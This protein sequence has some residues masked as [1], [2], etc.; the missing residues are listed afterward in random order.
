MLNLLV[1][2][3]AACS[4]KSLLKPFRLPLS[5]SQP[6]RHRSPASGENSLYIVLAHSLQ[7]LQATFRIPSLQTL[8]SKAPQRQH[9]H[10]LRSHLSLRPFLIHLPFLFSSSKLKQ[11]C[12]LLHRL[13]NLSRPIITS[14]HTLKTKHH[15]AQAHNVEKFSGVIAMLFE[16][17]HE[18]VK[19]LTDPLRSHSH[20]I[21]T[22]HFIRCCRSYSSPHKLVVCG[23]VTRCLT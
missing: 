22:H 13:S 23:T 16:N 7:S 21:E 4:F 6:H 8:H 1:K 17:V 15:S 5:T 19:H 18:S 9:Q 3:A 20:H 14:T 11:N 10:T 2:K 12:P